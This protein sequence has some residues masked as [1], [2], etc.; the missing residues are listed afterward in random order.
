MPE[1]ITSPAAVYPVR[2]VSA[3]PELNR[4]S[5]DV[6]W[7]HA[8]TADIVH[9]H[10]RSG[11][12]RPRCS[13]R[14]LLAESSL[15]LLFTVDD[16]FVQSVQTQMNSS[17]CTDSCVEF[18]VQPTDAGYFNFE[19]NAGGTIHCSYIRDNRITAGAFADYDF[20][21]ADLLRRVR[22][23]HTMPSIVY[24][25]ISVPVSWSIAMEIPMDV[26]EEYSGPP[27]VLPGSR[28]RGNF[29]KCADHTSHP[30]WASWHCIG[31][32]LNFHRPERFGVLEFVRR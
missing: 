9:Y 15:Y 13:A 20:L 29:F 31:E 32:E 7:A 4:F 1:L 19:V 25:E 14:L 5:E 18:F 26:F 3:P 8:A 22:I 27:S 2:R 16:C 21:P 17:V 6:A 30:H 23:A 28:W 10:P 24:P 11:I 12:H